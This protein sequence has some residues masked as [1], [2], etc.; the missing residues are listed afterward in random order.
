MRRFLTLLVAL[1]VFGVG[2][3]LGQVKQVTGVVTSADD[4]Q[5]IPGVSVFVKEAP[6]I[7][8]STDING[9]YILKNVPANAKTIVFRFVGYT[10]F[11][12]PVKSEINA[13]LQPEAKRLDEVVVTALGLSRDKKSVGYAVSTVKSEELLKARDG[14]VIN[15]LS[16]KVSGV[17]VNSQSGTLGGSSKVM[18]RGANSLDGNNQ[19]L[20]VVDGLPIDNG[21]VGFGGTNGASAD[22]GNRAGDINPDDIES[23]SVLKG[24]AATALY[25]ARAKNGAIVITTKRGSKK[26]SMSIS[27]NSSFRFDQVL[28]Y[29]KFQNEYAQGSYGVY[30]LK[31]ANGWGPKISDVQ[32]LKFKNFLGEDETLKAYKNNVENFFETG[33]TYMNS[34][35]LAGGGDNSDYRVNFSSLN[36]TGIIPSMKLDRYTVSVNAGKEF[37]PKLSARTSFSYIKTKAEG[38]PAQSSNNPN[39]MTSAIYGIPRTVDIEKLRSNYYNPTTGEQIGLTT[40]KTGNNPFWIMNNN[41]YNNEVERVMGSAIITYKPISWLTISNNLGTDFYNEYRF[42]NNKKGTF[43]DLDG[44]FSTDQIYNRIVNND[45]LVTFDET[46]YDKW[47]VKAMVGHNINQIEYRRNSVS[48][49]NL[50]VADLYTYSNAATT[51]PTNYYSKK[52]LVGVFG[53]VTIGYDNFAFFTVTGRNDWSS[54]LPINNRSYFYPSV[55]ASLIFSELLPKN[56]ILTFGK[57][58]LNWANVGSDEAP[59]QLAFDYSAASTYYV[60]YSLSGTFPHKNLI[61][62]TGPRT[63]PPQNLKPQNQQSYEFGTDLKFFGDRIGLTVNYYYTKTSD[64]IVAID[65]PLSTGYFAKKVNIGEVR[66]KGIEVDLNLKPVVYHDF[67]WDLGINFGA[68]EQ[69][70]EKL[71]EDEDATYT[72]SSGWSGL[73]IKAKKGDTFGLY[74][75]AWKRDAQGNLVINK[76][77][78]LR[79]TITDYRFGNIFPDWTM[80]INNNF[81]YK[82]ISL[83]F[84]IDIRQGGVFYS[85]T[86]ASL[87]TSG[88]A[89]ETLENRGKIFIDK[90]VVLNDD[91]KTYSPNTVPVQSMQDF[92]GQYAAT[93]NT[94]GNVYDASYIKFRELRL[95]YG[96]PKSL[97]S[98]IGVNNA[99]I[100]FEG[101]NLWIIKD[102]VPHVD[103]ESNFFGPSASGEGVEFNSVPS[104]KTY[105][106]N[107][108]LTF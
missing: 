64:Q 22:Y 25:G 37:S 57:V 79:E 51:T 58:R 53:D 46:F 8:A 2:S 10:S 48:A 98:K 105:G 16:G 42:S 88:L 89:E 69:T 39:V 95:S 36:Q 68:N 74:G 27:V 78:G 108:K 70:V 19:P 23:M 40:D 86:A 96:L 107:I 62:F 87:R 73:Q 84:L 9:R 24:A 30:D 102:H 80:G 103:P 54:T 17:R 45:F 83:G 15:S 106:F 76:N 1:V 41:K 52:R 71:L 93:A 65:V 12:M 100:G 35:A 7:G 90:G 32:D 14:N 75:T 31:Y 6:T 28:K 72:L 20:F 63:I 3:A 61:G 33:K 49:S 92:W 50:T 5:P 60:Q 104:T 85:G 82:N 43:G 77:T 44:S 47:N 18:I 59:Y 11:E 67:V 26:S 13:V 81:T 29:P 94:E 91:N 55:G 99:E 56:D 38:R 66:N 4:K 21:A 101:R 97:L 34:I